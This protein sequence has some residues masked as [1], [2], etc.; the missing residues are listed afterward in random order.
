MNT[1]SFLRG[2]IGQAILSSDTPP[3]SLR[4]SSV[5]K[6]TNQYITINPDTENEEIFYY[7]TVS[8]TP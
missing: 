4:V 8:G 3:F 7:T 6:N 2:R 1:E 5:P